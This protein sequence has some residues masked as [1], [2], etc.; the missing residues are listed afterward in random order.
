MSKG[1]KAGGKKVFMKEQKAIAA[2]RAGAV[3]SR[4]STDGRER[5]ARRRGGFRQNHWY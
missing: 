1:E 2:K 5:E 3:T 4:L